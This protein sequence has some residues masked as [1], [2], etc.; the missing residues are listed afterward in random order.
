MCAQFT[1]RLM[2]PWKIFWNKLDANKPVCAVMSY[3]ASA[4][5]AG[6]GSNYQSLLDLGGSGCC[7][8]GGASCGGC[9]DFCGCNPNVTIC[10]CCRLIFATNQHHLI[11]EHLGSKVHKKN[12][13]LYLLGELQKT[14][15][16]VQRLKS[17]LD[18]LQ[19]DEGRTQVFFYLKTFTPNILEINLANGSLMW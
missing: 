14:A 10:H 16:E 2:T 9:S 6:C 13:M 4:Y 11:E 18:E 3:Q 19:C 7:A 8:S 17:L 12:M 15:A 5:Q 1:T